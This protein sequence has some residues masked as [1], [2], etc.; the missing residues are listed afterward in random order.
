MQVPSLSLLGFGSCGISVVSLGQYT[1]VWGGG[2]V[3]SWSVA[4]DV[5]SGV[6]VE[7]LLTCWWPGGRP[8]VG[9]PENRN[10][11]MEES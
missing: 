6:G 8:G 4:Q 11:D 1:R 10:T 2:W 7:T 5:A 9:T 3:V